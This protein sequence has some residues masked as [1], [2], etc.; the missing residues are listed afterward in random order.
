MPVLKA[1]KREKVMKVVVAIDDSECSNA[2]LEAV[3]AQPW[4]KGTELRVLNVV[5]PLYYQYPFAGYCMAPMIDAQEELGKYHKQFVD[6]K[7]EYLKRMLDGDCVIKSEIIEGPAGPMIADFAQEWNADLIMLGSH[8]RSG[9]QKF[10]LG[11]VAE[12]VASLA[13]CSVEIIK[14]KLPQ[15]AEPE[16]AKKE[17][18]AAESGNAAEKNVAMKA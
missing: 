13:T 12:K 15:Q 5:E 4:P 2:A 17:S 14:A 9:F 18:K 11:S 10:F 16:E 3:V 1:L 7:V 8:G 6:E